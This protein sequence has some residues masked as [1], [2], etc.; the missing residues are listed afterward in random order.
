[1]LFS[2]TL[3]ELFITHIAGA[4]LVCLPPYS[5]DFNSIKQSFYTIKAWLQ[6][7]EA[8]TINLDVHPWLIHQALSSVTPKMAQ[9]WIE[10]CGYKFVL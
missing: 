7:H 9:R 8:E 10:N 3:S 5:P 1:M 4:R 2:I 6:R